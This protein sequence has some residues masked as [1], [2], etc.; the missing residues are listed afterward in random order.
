MG[1]THRER[2][3]A[4]IDHRETDRTPI[5]F[6][7]TRVSAIHGEAYRRLKE[8]LGI[9][10]ADHVPPEE[11]AK[12]SLVR[13]DVMALP[14]EPVLAR[15]DVDTRY[16]GLGAYEGGRRHAVDAETVI[17]EWGTTW[18]RSG[19]SHF[20]YTGGPFF[21][22]KKPDV[23]DLDAYD[24]PDPDNPGYYRGLGERARRLRNT[25]DAAIIL[26]LP[27]GPLSQGQFVRGF[28][29]WL[30][31]LYKNRAFVGRL[32][33]MIADHWIRIAHNALDAVDDNVDLF[34][35]SDDLGGQGGP[36]LGPQIYEQLV[37]PHH[38]RMIAAVKERADLKFLMHSC[39]SVYRMIP[40]LIDIGVDALNP[41]QVTARDMEPERLKGEFAGK[42]AFWGG[43]NS[44]EILPFA[45]PDAVRREVRRV[46]DCLGAGGGYVATSVHNIQR[47]VPPENIEA[48]FDEA[49]SYR[50]R[51]D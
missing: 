11:T 7:G 2:V 47:E 50:P 36:L 6:G 45:T 19:D 31:D 13:Q 28:G 29:D 49:R 44:Q 21:H 30:K 43:V 51:G 42:I 33:E 32:T 3:L 4:A 15:F 23:A 48:M 20:L 17:D 24:W 27:S 34:L 38:G 16:L 40:H 12:L 9:E 18:T 10:T 41:V 1:L 5:D 35:F 25:T 39:G 14:E 37:K 8:Y 26:N 46:I 22:T